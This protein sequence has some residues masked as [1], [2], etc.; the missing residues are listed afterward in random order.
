VGNSVVVKILQ[1]TVKLVEIQPLGAQSVIIH[2][3]TQDDKTSIY[4]VK[5]SD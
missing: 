5:H 3:H 2:T 4:Y 1:T